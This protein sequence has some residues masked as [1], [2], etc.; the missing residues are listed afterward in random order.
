MRWRIY[1]GDET[2]FTDADGSAFNAPA[3][4]V[5]AIAC[6]TDDPKSELGFYPVFRHD[7]YWWDEPFWYGGDLFGLFDY[8]MRPGPK[9]VLFGRSI[10]D[11]E[12]QAIVDR[13]CES[14]ELRRRPTR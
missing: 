5:Q 7:F 2:S 8:L 1:Y 3:L 11:P 9:K 13:A 12:H 14:P 4:N 6:K 10:P